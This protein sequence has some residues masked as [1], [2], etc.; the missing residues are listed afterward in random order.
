MT[1]QDTALTACRR[2]QARTALTL[3][4][5]LYVPAEESCES[6]IVVD[7]SAGGAGVTCENVPPPSAFVILHIEGFGRFEAVSTRFHN[8]ILGLKLLVPEERRERLYTQIAAFLDD[9]VDA[10]AVLGITSTRRL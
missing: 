3:P 4:G 1:Q 9:G 2:A 6:C 8:G 10:A 7:V 5:L